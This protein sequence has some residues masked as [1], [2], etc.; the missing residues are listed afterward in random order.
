ML[1]RVGLLYFKI[2]KTFLPYHGTRSFTLFR[3]FLKESRSWPAIKKVGRLRS[4]GHDDK[5]N[6]ILK[7]EMPKLMWWR[8]YPGY[9]R[10]AP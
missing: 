9:I 5:P 10:Q 6:V 1:D 4:S 3:L 2:A 7:N 8:A